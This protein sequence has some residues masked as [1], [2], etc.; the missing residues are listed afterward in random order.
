MNQLLTV[1]N[2]GDNTIPN[3]AV[4]Q[5]LMSYADLLI[6]LN[7]NVY[8]GFAFSWLELVSHKLFLPHFLRLPQ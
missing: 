1:I 3:L 4:V 7:P 8:P 5:I 2:E 6:Q